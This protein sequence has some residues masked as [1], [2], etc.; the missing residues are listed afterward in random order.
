MGF[1]FLFYV[2]ET[3][4][5]KFEFKDFGQYGAGGFCKGVR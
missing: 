1:L 2:K 4:Y 5:D 3:R